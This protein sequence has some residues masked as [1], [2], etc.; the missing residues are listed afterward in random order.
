[1]FKK[2]K[3]TERPELPKEYIWTLE[4]AGEDHEYKCLVTEEGVT[5]YEDGV[6]HKHLKITDPTCMEGVLQIDC[7]TKIFGDMVPFQLERFIPYIKLE[8][9]WVMSHTTEQDRMQQQIAIYKKQSKQE[10]VAGIIAILVAL[11]KW[12]FT[13]DMEDWW[14]L[15]VFGTF[16]ISSA[17]Y[18]MVRLRNELNALKE[19][20][21]EEAAEKA[22][23][24]ELKSTSV[25]QLIAETEEKQ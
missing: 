2:K 6:E 4:V 15:I 23:I 24:E 5:T 22:A 16:F 25:R 1:M 13:G 3:S 18:R 10:T 12:L 20:E 9:R 8:G 21:E 17:A 11:G 19:I 14:I 7:E